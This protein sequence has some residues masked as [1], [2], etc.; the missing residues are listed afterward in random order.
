M[1]I[2]FNTSPLIFLSKLN[3]LHE[4]SS[5]FDEKYISTGVID[6]IYKNISHEEESIVSLLE[7]PDFFIEQVEENRFY[8]KLRESLGLGE[9]E[10]I[11]LALKINSDYVILD[12][13][14]A[15]NKAKSF[16][17]TIKGTIG[18]LRNL[19]QENL[20]NIP[21]GK[22]YIELKKYNFRV[23]E[24]IYRSILREFYPV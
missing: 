5:I 10:A 7:G 9:T 6:E 13:K 17:L 22:I 16:G 23:D 4:V 2:V 20:L 3:L 8:K 24:K 12:D 1:K 15:R 18:I 14:A 21:P 11:M 19:Y